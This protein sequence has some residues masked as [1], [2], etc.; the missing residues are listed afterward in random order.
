[1]FYPASIRALLNTVPGA[2]LCP[3]DQ[4]QHPP[5]AKQW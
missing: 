3:K 1:M 2:R 4:P 5:N